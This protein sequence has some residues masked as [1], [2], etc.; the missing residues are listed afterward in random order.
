MT[1]QTLL[2]SVGA[3]LSLS[4]ALSFMLSSC[5]D[6]IRE[7]EHYKAPDF[8]VGN[9]L[10]VLQKPFEEHTFKTFLRVLSW[11]AATMWPTARY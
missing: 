10:E 11:W 7:D 1:K 3:G 8:L 5:Q 4:V 2:H 9:A 6:D